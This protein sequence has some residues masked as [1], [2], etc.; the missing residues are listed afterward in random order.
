MQ[1]KGGKRI[2]DVIKLD[3]LIQ[4][5]ERIKGKHGIIKSKCDNY[6][7]ILKKKAEELQK[8]VKEKMKESEAPF[9][10]RELIMANINQELIT[11]I[12]KFDR[13]CEE[14]LQIIA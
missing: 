13:L 6:Y 10:D 9:I 3:S 11:Y 14:A 7:Q 4:E 2:H 5:K 8:K 1:F 12:D